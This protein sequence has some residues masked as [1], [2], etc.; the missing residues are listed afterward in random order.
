MLDIPNVKLARAFFA[1]SNI[2][3]VYPFLSAARCWWWSWIRGRVEIQGVPTKK[4]VMMFGCRRPFE[5]SQEQELRTSFVG[6]IPNPEIFIFAATTQT[7]TK[8]KTTTTTTTIIYHSIGSHY[9][10]PTVIFSTPSAAAPD[11]H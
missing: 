8:T 6:N 2:S 1:F 10:Y 5:I 11:K 3:L 9:F 4:K 7:T